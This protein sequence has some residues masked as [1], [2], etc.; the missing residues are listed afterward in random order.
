MNVYNFIVGLAIIGIGLILN[1]IMILPMKKLNSSKYGAF[2]NVL[3]VLLIAFLTNKIANF[4]WGTIPESVM[5]HCIECM[6]N[7]VGYIWDKNEIRD[8]TVIINCFYCIAWCI[9]FS[10]ISVIQIVKKKNIGDNVLIIIWCIV[11]I[12]IILSMKTDAC[13]IYYR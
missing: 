8:I 12:L 7:G 3:I 11:S 9:Y 6:I 10:A 1:I 4:L 2:W 13:S 5:P